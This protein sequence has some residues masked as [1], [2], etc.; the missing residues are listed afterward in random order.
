MAAP[1]LSAAR[2]P[3]LTC[4]FLA[5]S[6]KSR[7]WLVPA[8]IDP[9]FDV[10]FG[11]AGD[12]DWYRIVAQTTGDLDIRV[13]FHQQGS[14]ANGRAGLPGDGNLDIALYDNDGVITG[15]PTGGAIAGV[16]TFGA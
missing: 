12:E 4:S 6:K 9:G 2:G 11:A 1:V 16:G 8:T 15:F 13:L 5:L 10:S 3:K 14:L 7:F